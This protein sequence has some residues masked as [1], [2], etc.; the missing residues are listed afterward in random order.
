MLKP[1]LQLKLGQQ[2]TMTPQLQQAIRLLQLPALELQAH[3]RELLETNVMLEPTEEGEGAS[4]F[5]AIDATPTADQEHDLLDR[6]REPAEVPER[7]QEEN[8]VEVVDEGWGEQSVGSAEA[9]WNSDDDERL[10]VLAGGVRG[11]RQH[12]RPGAPRG[13]GGRREA[14]ADAAVD[15]VG[16][17]AE[18]RLE[19]APGELADGDDRAG[20]AGDQ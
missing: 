20:A 1:S 7:A 12:V 17:D 8:T 13:R 6:N 2:L 3:I 18:Q 19:L 5:E 15:D 11:D 16:V 10:Q 9:P 4:T 14:R